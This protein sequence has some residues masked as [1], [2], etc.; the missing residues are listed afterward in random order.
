[1]GINQYFKK[2]FKRYNG[3]PIQNFKG[4][5]FNYLIVLSLAVTVFVGKNR[6]NIQK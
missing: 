3:F 1:V 6:R 2:I 4:M 5:A